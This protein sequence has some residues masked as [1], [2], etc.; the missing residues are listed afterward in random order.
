MR[1]AD[2]LLRERGLQGPSRLIPLNVAVP[3]LEAASLEENDDLQDLWAALF[4]NAVD[5]DSDVEVKRMFVSILQD[6]GV[7][8]AEI[9][10]AIYMLSDGGKQSVPTLRLPNGLGPGDKLGKP[11]E[12]TQVVLWNLFRL[13]CI[14]SGFGFGHIPPL[15]LV[16]PTPLGIALVRACTNSHRQSDDSV[17]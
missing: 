5:A 11:P 16:V 17:R 13:G 2:E 10:T 7:L 14:E 6:V 8:D 12:A 9:L 4:V 1:R 3:I 15:T